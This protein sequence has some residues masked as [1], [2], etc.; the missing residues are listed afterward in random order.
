MSSHFNRCSLLHLCW[1]NFL[2]THRSS[3]LSKPLSSLLSAAHYCTNFW[4]QSGG[5]LDPCRLLLSGQ[6]SGLAMVLEQA[7]GCC[8]CDCAALFQAG[9]W[10]GLVGWAWGA[11][12]A[13][14]AYNLTT[15][16]HTG[17]S[18]GSV[19]TYRWYQGGP[20]AVA[21]APVQLFF[22]WIFGWGLW[23]QAAWVRVGPCLDLPATMPL[24]LTPYF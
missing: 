11:T 12:L 20:L 9:L 7:S 8:S 15:L 1:S 2:L 3:I 24:W 14:P 13:R 5:L 21:S 6:G 4:V 10:L 23:P 22:R 17:F 18:L 19:S 16:V